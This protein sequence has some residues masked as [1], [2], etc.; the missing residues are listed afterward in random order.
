MSETPRWD[1]LP[2]PQPGRTPGWSDFSV[3]PRLH[4]E[5]RASDFDRAQA[6]AIVTTGFAEGRLSVAERDDRLRQ[7]DQATHLGDLVPLVRDVTVAEPVQNSVPVAPTAPVVRGSQ[8]RGFPR[9]WLRLALL[10]NAIWLVTCVTSGHL[11]YYWPLWPML[12]TA[13][14]VI[15]GAMGRRSGG[16]R[17]VTAEQPPEALPPG[18]S[19]LR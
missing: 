8:R 9:W 5:L 10:F 1:N 3:D 7:V 14:P 16:D 15:M 11:Q 13:I 19:D 12:G 2:A 18:K 17:G 4:P 6:S